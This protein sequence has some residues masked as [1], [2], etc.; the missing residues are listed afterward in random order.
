RKDVVEDQLV[1]ILSGDGRLSQRGQQMKLNFSVGV[2]QRLADESDGASQIFFCFLRKSGDQR[3]R[4][5]DA[6][7]VRASDSECRIS[8]VQT[9]VHQ[10]L[11]AIR[12]AVDAEEDSRAPIRGH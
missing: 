5:L 8:E 10:R 3:D 2:T 1:L 6:T 12:T 11:H 7:A 9:L 4:V